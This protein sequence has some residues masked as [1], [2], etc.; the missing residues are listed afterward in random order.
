MKLH[1]KKQLNQVN[2]T[3]F[4]FIIGYN[5]NAFAI[6]N[7]TLELQTNGLAKNSGMST[8]GENSASQKQVIE[9]IV[10]TNSEKWL[11]MLL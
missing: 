6:G 7:K 8:V 9:K 1:T 4:D 5:T 3:L 10:T 2:E 11:N